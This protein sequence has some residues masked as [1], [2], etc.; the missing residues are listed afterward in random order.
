[1]A[2]DAY[3][4]MNRCDSSDCK[5]NLRFVLNGNESDDGKDCKIKSISLGIGGL[6]DKYEPKE[7]V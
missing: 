4:G 5:H 1:M 3:P 7:E 2:R 6:C